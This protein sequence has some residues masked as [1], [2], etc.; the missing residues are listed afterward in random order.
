[1]KKLYLGVDLGGTEIK[2]AIVDQFGVIIEET[3]IAN[4]GTSMPKAVTGEIIRQARSM[5]NFSHV[6][7]TGVGV[8]GDIDQEKGFVRFSP[9]L[10][11]WKK[12]PLRTMLRKHLPGE[13]LV[14]NDANVAALGAC[15][16]DA[17]GKARNLIC[18]TL[19]TGVG[20]G[21]VCQGKL[22]RG[23]SG[24]AGEI[25]HMSFDHDGP[26]C[27][28]G[29]YGCIERYIGAPY[30]SRFAEGLVEAEGSKIISELVKNN[31]NA[32]SPAVL[33]QAALMGDQLAKRIW[34]DAGEKL[35][36]V[37]ASVINFYNPDMI[38]LAGGLSKA[39]RLLLDPVNRMVKARAFTTSAK[40][41]KIVIS[42][43]TQKLGVVGAALLAK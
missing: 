14:D 17:H 27:N 37:L 24:T 38:V 1:V 31:L 5:R 26:K 41:C 2:I 12:V 7:G 3:G 43:Y 22:Y 20:G 6:V 35:G 11:N 15:W 36:V 30:L 42:R 16:L 32:I 34:V 18:V 23:S 4:S 25:G 9:N 13:I 8:A 39:G 33:S 40:E 19:G 21:I 29:S 28:C 10:A